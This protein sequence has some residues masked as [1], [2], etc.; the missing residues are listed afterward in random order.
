LLHSVARECR[1]VRLHAVV[2]ALDA[3]LM[4]KGKFESV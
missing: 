2:P 1:S 3:L 4:V